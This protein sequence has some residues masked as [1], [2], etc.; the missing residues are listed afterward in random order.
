MKFFKSILLFGVVSFV[1]ASV[2]YFVISLIFEAPLGALY[3]MLL[4]HHAHPYQYISVVAVVYSIIAA[5]WAYYFHNTKK[6]KRYL[7]IGIVLLLTVAISNIACG[8][9]W[10]IHDMQAGCFTHGGRFYSDLIWGAK[11]GLC[12]GWLI[13][14]LSIPYNIIMLVV[15]VILTDRVTKLIFKSNGN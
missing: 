2:I 13:V 15:G 11:T 8:V 7:G 10:K 4:Y 1:A 5:T 12:L 6:W 9:L 3:R 14:A